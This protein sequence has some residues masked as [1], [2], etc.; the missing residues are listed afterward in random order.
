VWSVLHCCCI[1]KLQFSREVPSARIFFQQTEGLPH[2]ITT[3]KNEQNS[4]VIILIT[5]ILFEENPLT[6]ISP[7]SREDTESSCTIHKQKRE[8]QNKKTKLNKTKNRCRRRRRRSQR[9][10]VP[11]KIEKKNSLLFP[12]PA[13]HPFFLSKCGTLCDL[14]RNGNG[15]F[16]MMY[17]AYYSWREKKKKKKRTTTTTWRIHYSLS[18]GR[19][20]RRKNRSSKEGENHKIKTKVALIIKLLS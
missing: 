6:R 3:T 16:V 14:E 15:L 8:I 4:V 9:A 18:N 5:I 19:N 17:K 11:G 12:P 20:Q 13:T 1:W 10:F 7:Y 2:T